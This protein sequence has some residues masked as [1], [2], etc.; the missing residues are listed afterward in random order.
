MFPNENQ[1]SSLN[2]SLN[3]PVNS[4]LKSPLISSLNS[5]LKSSLNSP[6]KSPINQT[7]DINKNNIK[8]IC[9]FR[10]LLETEIGS[11]SIIDYHNHQMISVLGKDYTSKFTFDTIFPP[12]T[13]QHEVYLVSIQQTVDDF[14]NG[15]NGTILTYGQT[16]SGKSYTMMGSSLYD[17]NKGIIPRI[18]DDIFDKISNPANISTEYI[19]KVSYYEIYME[20]INDLLSNPQSSQLTPSKFTIH[21]DKINGIHIKNLCQVLVTSSQQLLTILQQGLK[22]RSNSST[23]MNSQSSRSHAIFQIKLNQK[24]ITT[25]VTKLSQLFLVDL[26]GSENID[27]SGAVGQT[28]EEAKK[29]N[30]S[31]SALGNVINALTDGKST[32]IPYRD[33]KLT[34]ILQES[35]GGNA[36]TSLIIN[37]SPSSNNECETI[38][39]L[40]FGTR[41]K[42]IKNK[43]HINEELSPDQKIKHLENLNLQNQNYIKELEEELHLW[44]NGTLPLI[45][46]NDSSH[47]NDFI[48]NHKHVI[49]TKKTLFEASPLYPTSIPLSLGSQDEAKS[50]LAV[51]ELSAMSL[52]VPINY[53]EE[54]ERRDKKI[55][56]LEDKLLN[57]KMDNLRYSHTEESKLFTLENALSKLNKKLTEVELININLRKHLSI[58]EKIIESRDTKINNLKTSLKEQQVLISK[59]TLDFR[60]KLGDIQSKLDFLNLKKEQKI[61][62]I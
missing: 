55:R 45:T 13:C 36:R 11:K 34:R 59:E 49:E 53:N 23:L 29:I 33:S 56:E 37:C 22:N 9:R 20:S 39:T 26:A 30:S 41:A 8:V 1:D 50:K 47:T 25:E 14:L 32:H 16:G 15:Y 58:S 61:P 40:R 24:N 18:S 31:L 3:S 4:S 5:P 19:V 17:Q 46:L 48:N 12:K 2:S 38:S 60:L 51:S 28:L 44:R 57:L 52:A 62:T 6:L 42:F 21:Q 54:I 35:L 7:K 10:P 27:K 43:P